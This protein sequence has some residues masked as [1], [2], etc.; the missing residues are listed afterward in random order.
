KIAATENLSMEVLLPAAW[1]HDCVHVPKNSSERS[2]A[3]QFA[4]DNAIIILRQHGYPQEHFK[5]IHHA[6]EAHSFSAKITPSTIEAK[7]LQDADRIDALGAIGLSRCLMLG[8]HMGSGLYHSE[9]P[10]AKNRPLNDTN[11]CI[12][13]F[14]AKLLTLEN[15]MQTKAGK[16]L[17]EKRT[18]FL[19]DFLEQLR[20]EIPDM[21]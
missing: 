16:A 4:A 17:A 7:V 3:S 6:I 21:S 1:L 15:T 13:H 11:Y 9:D 19:S 20:T 10:F 8:G 2:S 18:K 5:A 14:Y 12:D